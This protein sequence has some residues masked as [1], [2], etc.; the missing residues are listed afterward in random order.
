MTLNLAPLVDVMMCLIV[1]FLL[2]SKM[3]A[4]ELNPVNLAWAMASRP[5]E[6]GDLG[7][8]VTVTVRR[9]LGDETAE[10][11]VAEW[12]GTQIVERSLSSAEIERLLV[13]RANSARERSRE[14]RCVVR[15]D[16]MIRYRHVEGVLRSC[17]L[18]KIR[19]VVFSVNE[20]APPES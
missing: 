11:V 5:V 13:A 7:D 19:N 6:P 9:G 10:Y 3:V 8:R 14:L 20:G 12:D 17:G 15:A 16:R 18:A 4:A 1:F 2:A